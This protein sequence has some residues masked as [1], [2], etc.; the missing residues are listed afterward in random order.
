[1]LLDA[2]MI[3]NR[4]KYFFSM[5]FSKWIHAWGILK[6]DESCILN[7]E[8]GQLQVGLSSRESDLKFR[9]SDLRC[10]IRPISKFPCSF[11]QPAPKRSVGCFLAINLDVQLALLQILKLFGRQ[12]KRPRYGSFR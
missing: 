1:M 9:V 4:M 10:R 7:P 12:V 2:A 5:V 8:I 6:S 3:T 11:Q